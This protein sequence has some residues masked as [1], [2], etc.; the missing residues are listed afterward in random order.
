MGSFFSGSTKN[1]T[2]TNTSEPWKEQKPYLQDIMKQ[3]QYLY[4][5]DNPTYYP[6]NTVAG[7][8]PQQEQAFG[9]AA[10]R[11]VNGNANMKAAAGYNQDVLSGK[12]SGDPYQSQVFQNIQSQVMPAIN[13]QFS[14]AGRYGSGA[15]A[16][17][18]ARGLTDAFAPYATQMYQNSL[19][20]MGQAAAFAPTLAQNDYTDI[21]ALADVG[22]QRQLLAQQEIQDAQNRYNYSQDAPYNKLGQYLQFVGGN[23]GGTTT[24]QQPYQTQSPFSQILGGG[25]GLLGLLG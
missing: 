12:Y 11:A 5:N 6:G 18:A 25:L 17:S 21:A 8:S 15:H 9:M 19:D 4:K 14:S 20:R 13:S 24:S 22:Q 2:T 23:Y 3:A 1:A 7:F 10:N 16:D